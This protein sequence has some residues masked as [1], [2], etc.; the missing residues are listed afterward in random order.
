M[1][2]PHPFARPHA[3]L[4]LRAVL[5]RMY[6]RITHA[7]V[8]AAERLCASWV[9]QRRQEAEEYLAAAT[10]LADLERRL[11]EVERRG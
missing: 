6:R 11:K 5:R 2:I 1:P 3:R 9:H 7:F 4:A 8:L 10:D